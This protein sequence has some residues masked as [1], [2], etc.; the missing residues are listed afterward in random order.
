VARRMQ[1][2]ASAMFNRGHGA[3]AL[4]RQVRVSDAL[5]P[6][7]RRALAIA[8]M[9]HWVDRAT[10][11][12]FE[13]LLRVMPNDLEL[14]RAKLQALSGAM[15]RTGW[16]DRASQIDTVLLSEHLANA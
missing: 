9:S 1:I 8:L 4:V 5:P 13:Q 16:S 15:S 10:P 11:E 3:D 7:G 6:L 14:T 2:T 12:A